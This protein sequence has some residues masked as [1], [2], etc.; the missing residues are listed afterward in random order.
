M[1]FQTLDNK[2]ECIGVFTNGELLFE[3][4]PDGLTHTWSYAPY[5][6]KEVKY[7][8][9]YCQGLSPDQVCPENLKGEWSTITKK[10]KAFLKSFST[11]RV[12]LEEVCFFDLVPERFL[13]EYCD[14]KNR[15]SQHVFEAYREPKNYD[16]LVALTEMVEEIERNKLNLDFHGARNSLSCAASVRSYKKIQRCLPRVKYNTFGTKTGRLSTKKNSFPILN[17]DRRYRE[18]VK[19]TNDCFIELDFNAAELRTLLSLSGHDQ[20]AGDLHEWNARNIYGGLVT[21]EVAKKRIF[22]W[23]YNPNSHVQRAGQFYNR[24]K[25]LTRYW[26][27]EKVTTPFHREILADDAHALNYLIQST[28]SDMVLRQAIKVRNLLSGRKSKL[29][30][31]VHD[32]IVIDYSSEDK[33]MLDSLVSCFS[34]TELGKFRVG[35]Q[36]GKDYGSMRDLKWTQS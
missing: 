16:F 18:V 31:I 19:P 17:L 2:G 12:D 15:I 23:L 9:L 6:G 33:Q 25:I 28:C 14:L 22:S 30:F 8:N 32:S 4:L 21:R 29:I 3:E 35:V 27:G 13:R 11:S 7:A 20:P 26:D 5:L 10:M 24:R 34:E 36:M 1:I